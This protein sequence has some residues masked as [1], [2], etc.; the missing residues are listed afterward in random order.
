MESSLKFSTTT[1]KVFGDGKG[2]AVGSIEG[3]LSIEYYDFE[4][5]D[6]GRE[7]DFC[8]KCHRLENEQ[9]KTAEVYPVNGIAFNK[10]Y[11][12]FCTY[13]GDGVVTI[14]NKDVKSKYRTYK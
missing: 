2:Y 12:T 1:I 5:R 6:R 14:W 11:N 8:F 3:R 10:K 7:L 13:G 9:L 4:R